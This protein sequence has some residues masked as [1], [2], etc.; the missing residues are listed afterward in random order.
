MLA[1]NWYVRKRHEIAWLSLIVHVANKKI[2]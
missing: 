2:R 1:F